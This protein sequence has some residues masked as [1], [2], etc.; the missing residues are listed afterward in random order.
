MYCTHCGVELEPGL[1]RCPLCGGTD[2]SEDPAFLSDFPEYEPL[3]ERLEKARIGRIY[4]RLVTLLFGT[5]A[6]VVLITDLLDR[7]GGPDWSPIAIAGIAAGFLFAI[8]PSLRLRLWTNFALDVA[9]AGALL[10]AID[11][12][13]DG[14]VDWFTGIALPILGAMLVLLLAAAWAM[15]RVRGVAKPAVIILATAILCVVVDLAIRLDRG[16][17]V[18]PGWSLVV[19]ASA[20]P[21]AAFLVLLQHT[22]L[23]EI[24]LRRRFYF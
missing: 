24:D 17:P 10:L 22:V 11:R 19:A 14:T 8:L 9:I 7:S 1:T 23:R 5:A 4:R 6:M 13:E 20:G 18:V 16:L 2:L 21:V 3:P 12:L 15:P